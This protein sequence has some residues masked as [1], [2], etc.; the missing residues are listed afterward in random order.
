MKGVCDGGV[1]IESNLIDHARTHNIQ[2]AVAMDDPEDA[3][4]AAAM[5]AATVGV[6]P[7]PRRHHGRSSSS[8]RLLVLGMLVLLLVVLPTPTG[9]V[10]AATAA[11]SIFMSH[12]EPDGDS[13]AAGPAEHPSS[14][15]SSSASAS[16]A[17]ALLPTAGASSNAA[18]HPS[19]KVHLV[20]VYECNRWTTLGGWRRP[21]GEG[22]VRPWTY[23]D[24]G[25]SLDPQ[26]RGVFTLCICRECV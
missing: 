26:V 1:F 4:P 2:V 18:K 15:P 8:S 20:E 11:A 23:E 16:L 7:S 22:K 13:D 3:A 5:V 24:G 21:T 10:G 12:P 6:G 17:S 25:E 19:V 9:A 14:S